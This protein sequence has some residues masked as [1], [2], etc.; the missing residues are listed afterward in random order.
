MEMGRFRLWLVGIW[1]LTG[2]LGT[3]L[4]DMVVEPDPSPIDQ[5]LLIL[6]LPVIIIPAV[7]GCIWTS[8]TRRANDQR[9]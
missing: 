6:I 9:S 5:V 4:V 2:V 1:L 7:I 8:W 3:A